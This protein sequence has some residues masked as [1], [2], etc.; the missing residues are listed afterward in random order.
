[1]TERT[2]EALRRRGAELQAAEL[3]RA[4]LSPAEREA[5][6]AVLSQLL[7]EV[8]RLVARGTSPREER[9]LLDLF[10]LEEAA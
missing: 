7:D 2:L 9:V 4:R 6:E 8:V 10:A 1:M 5:A 3:A